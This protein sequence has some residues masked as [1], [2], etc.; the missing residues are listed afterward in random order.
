MITA[1]H[2]EY[3]NGP[4]ADH[5]WAETYFLPIP[6]PEQHILAHVYVVVRPVLGVMTN[7]VYF[8]GTMTD[9][10]TELLHYNVRNQLPAPERWSLIDSPM[11]L[12]IEATKPPR[13]YRIDYVGPDGNEIHV[14][15]IGMMEPFDIHDPA[16]SPNAGGTEEERAARSS[17]GEAYK[18]HYDMTGR[19]TGTIIVNGREFP[20]D[21]IERMDRSWGRRPEEVR[22]MNSINATF[23]PD[24]A[25]HFRAPRDAH[26]PAREPIEITHGYILDNGEMVAIAEGSFVS[27]RFGVMLLTLDCT[28]TDVKGR[29]YRL[30]AMPDVG[31]PWTAYPACITW[32]SM[33]K[34]V[35]GERVGYGVVME[36]SVIRDHTSRFGVWPT[37]M[38]RVLRA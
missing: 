2:L 25:F 8:Y 24:L 13:E 36:N 35:Y 33:M 27:T 34:W 14:D 28:L 37:D 38:P 17:S 21:S 31:A 3:Q 23:G 12:R 16:H 26:G 1:E 29:T 22:P 6:V 7:D 32:N 15:W 20:V 5:D 18:G 19:I 9:S 30:H 4:D 10:R 11:G